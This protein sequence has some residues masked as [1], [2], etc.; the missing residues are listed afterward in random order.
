MPRKEAPT[1]YP[2]SMWFAACMP[3]S[4]KALFIRCIETNEYRIIAAKVKRP[5][6]VLGFILTLLLSAPAYTN[7][8]SAE[9]VCTCPPAEL[10]AHSDIDSQRN[11]RTWRGP[12]PPASIFYQG[13]RALKHGPRKSTAHVRDCQSVS[14]G[15]NGEEQ[16][17]TRGKEA[18]GEEARK[19]REKLPVERQ[20][21]AVS[22]E[23][24]VE[25]LL[26]EKEM[27]VVKVYRT[28]M[29]REPDREITLPRP[30]SLKSWPGE[31]ALLGALT[32]LHGP[33]FS[34]DEYWA[35]LEW[36]A[37]AGA[38]LLAS[39]GGKLYCY[40]PHGTLAPL[41]RVAG[42]NY[43]CNKGEGLLNYTHSL[44]SPQPRLVVD[45]SGRF[46]RL[47]GG[48]YEIREDGIWN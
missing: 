48:S 14:G 42:V 30:A 19:V 34:G 7:L 21:E 23:R 29:H 36:G 24:P 46:G 4:W 6:A 44:G 26:G 35:W 40:D 20:L 43:Y 5:L 41:V 22:L 13:G 32:A 37:H 27:S 11:S 10:C 17:E 8:R 16:E 45:A 18:C 47:V 33:R 2:I 3:S 39:A 38:M 31:L 25:V 15:L 12:T 1:I 9:G 28:F